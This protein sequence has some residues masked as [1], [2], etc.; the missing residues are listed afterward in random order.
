MI[1][2]QL[3]V[4]ELQPENFKSSLA[5][6]A[7]NFGRV[8]SSIVHRL[9]SK[10]FQVLILLQ[11]FS[12]HLDFVVQ[13]MYTYAYLTQSHVQATPDCLRCILQSTFPHL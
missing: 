3:P 6:Y 9:I 13:Y 8:K 12:E 1:E 4:F 2:C 7:K 10:L 5:Y 11:S